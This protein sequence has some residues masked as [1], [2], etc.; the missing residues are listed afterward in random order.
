MHRSHGVELP[1]GEAVYR[2]GDQRGQRAVTERGEII[3]EQPYLCVSVQKGRWGPPVVTKLTH[4]VA[5]RRISYR[6]LISH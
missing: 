5:G 6:I 3:G 4:F 1:G 2:C